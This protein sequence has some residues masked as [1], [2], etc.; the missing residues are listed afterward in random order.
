LGAATL[1]WGFVGASAI[2]ARTLRA[3][4]DQHPLPGAGGQ[5]A[6]THSRIIGL[7]SHN[8]HRARQFAVDQAVPQVFINLADL[9]AHPDIHCVYISSHPRHHAQTVMAALA[10]GKHVLCEPPLALTLDDAQTAAH[11]ALSRGLVLGVNYLRRA[12]PALQALRE[13]IADGTIGDLL[14]GRVSNAIALRPALQTWR[15]RPGGGGVLFDRTLHSVDLVRYLLRDEA[16]AI[17]SLST[18]H[19]LGGEDGKG[20]EG[21][22]IAEAVDE[23]VVSHLVLRRSGLVFQLHDSFLVPH[24]PTTVEIHGS[25]GTLVARH[26]LVDDYPSELHLIR[27][28]QSSPLPLFSIDLYQRAM[29]LFAEAVRGRGMPLATGTDGVQSLAI[30]LA[31]QEAI[32]RKRQITLTPATRSLTD[33]ALE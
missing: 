16:A 27:H 23:D 7:F 11:T 24:T 28:G 21:G 26:C 25:A 31:A 15:L 4:R 30:V 5:G 13:Q 14:G 1:G 20:N 17:H 2:A 3:I 33:R 6:I 18:Q 12:D 32:R 10:A 29:Q 22:A 9:L 19:I 8:E